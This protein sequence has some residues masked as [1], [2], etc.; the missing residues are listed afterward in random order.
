MM[1]KILLL[2]TACIAL[3][4]GAYGWLVWQNNTAAPAT[5][6][7]RLN[8]ALE[9]A[10][11]WL[12]VNQS[13]LIE[14]E[15]PVLWWMLKESLDLTEHERLKSVFAQ[16]KKQWL[17]P[18]PGAIWSPMFDPSV[19]V[20][21]PALN[22]LQNVSPYKL[23]FMY[24][25]T[26]DAAFGREPAIRRQ[27]QAD[28]CGV[29]FLNPRCATHQL[30]GV[31]LMQRNACGDDAN[32]DALTA[33]LTDRIVRELTWDPRVVDAYVQRVLVLVESGAFER[34][35][36]V[37]IERIVDSQNEDGG[38]GD[39]APV[40]HLPGGKAFGIATSK[41]VIRPMTSNFHAT[42]QGIWLISLLLD[43]Q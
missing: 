31:R 40:I 21:Q 10:I 23:L 37:W 28:Y 38:W 34:V 2:L 13:D 42:A 14:I 39:L 19:Y 8:L 9:A 3:A 35:K 4:C 33:R 25:L 30:M 41:I 27:L 11:D 26:C 43:R 36:P 15:N 5:D 6:V 7:A 24:G 18:N 22:V 16:Y 1:R 32:L 20:G 17:D 12:E 29:A